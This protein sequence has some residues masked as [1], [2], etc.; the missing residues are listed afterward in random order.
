MVQEWLLLLLNINFLKLF[1]VYAVSSYY[2][3]AMYLNIMLFFSCHV[4]LWIMILKYLS[5]IFVAYYVFFAERLLIFADRLV[6]LFIV[7]F[8][9]G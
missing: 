7:W 3:V 8:W 6:I 9:F 5:D 2:V 4:V 1:S